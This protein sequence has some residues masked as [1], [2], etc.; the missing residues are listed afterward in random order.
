MIIN[1]NEKNTVS[2]ITNHG[3]NK[4]GTLVFNVTSV[5]SND[6]IDCKVNQNNRIINLTEEK[7][8]IKPI[9]LIDENDV[10]ANHSAL[11]GKFSDEEMFYLNSRGIDDELALNLLIKGFLKDMDIN[12]IY[13]EKIEKEIDNYWR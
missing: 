12:D 2:D 7:C 3:V 8:E 9:L 13:K 4:E 1:H 10:E 5:V 6:V 11:I